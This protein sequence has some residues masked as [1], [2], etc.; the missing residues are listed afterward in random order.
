[1][2]KQLATKVILTSEKGLQKSLQKW[3]VEAD[4]AQRAC[5]HAVPTV[6]QLSLQLG[7]LPSGL[8]PLLPSLGW[9][10]PEG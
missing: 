7:F 4:D 10:S 5:P 2:Y 3:P 6:L 1:M 9:P 8:H